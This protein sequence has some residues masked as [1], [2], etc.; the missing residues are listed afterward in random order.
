MATAVE[1]TPKAHADAL[2]TPGGASLAKAEDV[3]TKAA[4]A[5]AADALPTANT[6]ESVAVK[7]AA[8]ILGCKSESEILSHPQFAEFADRKGVPPSRL[9]AEKASR[10]KAEGPRNS[11]KWLSNFNI[12]D[13]LAQWARVFPE[14]YAYPFAMMDFAKT[15][16]D[17]ATVNVCEAMRRRR[18]Q[19]PFKCFG[20]VVNTDVSTGR[21]RHWVAVFIDV[22]GASQPPVWTVEYFNSTGRPPPK[23]M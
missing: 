13:T 18:P 2:N 10:F 17:L 14:F 19:G 15:G 4:A 21:G 5:R 1:A 8:A 20:C 22:R 3:H 7:T 6:K 23:P 9:E 16:S 11:R 12:D